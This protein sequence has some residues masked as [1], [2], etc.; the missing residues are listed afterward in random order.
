[1][2][3]L[4]LDS[5]GDRFVISIDKNYISKDAL[6]QMLERIRVEQ[7]AQKIDFQ[8]GIEQLGEEMK[9]SWWERNHSRLLDQDS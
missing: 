6:F 3:P 2:N 9:D 8:E 4:S 7:L 5:S 1:M